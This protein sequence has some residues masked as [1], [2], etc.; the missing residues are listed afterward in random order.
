LTGRS[1]LPE[2]L[3]FGARARREERQLI[4]RAD[5]LLAQV[6]LAGQGDFRADFLPYG[7]ARRLEI[8]RALGAK[9]SLLLRDEPAAGMNQAEIERMMA[10]IRELAGAGQTILLIEHH[11]GLVM[12]VCQRIAVLNFGQK[13]AE[14]TPAE[15][16]A[17]TAVIEAYLGRE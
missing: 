1:M 10:L 8:A 5:A 9:P 6:G 13:I 3:V 7:D 4:A 2:A 12:S 11:V 16:Q 15:I 14:G 17:D